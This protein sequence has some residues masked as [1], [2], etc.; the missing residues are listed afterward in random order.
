ME[1]G[2]AFKIGILLNMWRVKLCLFVYGED[3]IEMKEFMM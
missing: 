1:E 2:C 3:L